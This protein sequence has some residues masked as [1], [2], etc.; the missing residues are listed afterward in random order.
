ML[1]RKSIISPIDGPDVHRTTTQRYLELQWNTEVSGVTVWQKQ[2][3]YIYRFTG[4]SG[5]SN[6]RDCNSCVTEYILYF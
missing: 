4:R 6:D 5:P 3:V 1:N 2:R